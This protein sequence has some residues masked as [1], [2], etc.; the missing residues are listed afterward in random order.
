MTQKNHFLAGFA[1][2]LFAPFIGFYLYYLSFFRQMSVTDF[3]FALQNNN[4]LAAAISLS[5]L[6]NLALFFILDR[7][8]KLRAEQG[9]IAA[10]FLYGFYIM[11]LK[12]F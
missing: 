12:F 1:G 4:T 6:A 7:F 9:V 11:Y 5:L 8:R 3:F 10:T 2:G